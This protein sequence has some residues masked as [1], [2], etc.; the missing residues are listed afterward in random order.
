MSVQA[1]DPGLQPRT[2]LVTGAWAGRRG[3]RP[4]TSVTGA[5]VPGYSGRA[6]NV[7]CQAAWV[8]ASSVDEPSEA[9]LDALIAQGTVGRRNERGLNRTEPG[10][11]AATT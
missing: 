4:W 10:S 3:P 2:V 1:H 11:S 6:D 8:E 7:R 5:E 9:E